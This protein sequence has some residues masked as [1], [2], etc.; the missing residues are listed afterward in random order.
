MKKTILLSALLAGMVLAAFKPVTRHTDVYKVD[1]KAS[2][3]EWFASKKSGN[4]NGTVNYN[5]G[6]I[7]NDH[8]NLSGSVEVDMNTIRNSDVSDETY[9]AKLEGHLK[10]AD[11][12]D[13]AKFPKATFVITSVTPVKESKTEGATHN[14]K[15]NLTIKDKTNPISFDA[16]IKMEPGRIMCTGSAIVDRAKYDVKYGSKAFFPEIGEKIIYDEFTLQFNI[17]AV[18]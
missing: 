5:S 7:H 10:S 6:E 11:F 4:H 9:K 18:K 12:F 2:T 17:V 15:G 8:G 3:L 1:T 13:V 14:V 16:V